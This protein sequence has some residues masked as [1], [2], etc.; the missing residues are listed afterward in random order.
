MAT[1]MSN[2]R[3]G[4][5]KLVICWRLILQILLWSSN[6]AFCHGAK[7]LQKHLMNEIT[8]TRT[9]TTTPMTTATSVNNIN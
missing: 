7:G 8:T 9:T 4:I 6:V 2:N 5:G 1:R 3:G